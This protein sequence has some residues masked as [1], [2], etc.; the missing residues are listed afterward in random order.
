MKSASPRPRPAARPAAVLWDMDG[1]IVDTEPYWIEC[2]FELVEQFGDSWDMDKAHA[3]VGS[4]LRDTARLMQDL[5]GVRLEVDDIVNRLLDGVV[6]R[7]RRAVPWRAGAREL[8]AELNQADIPCALVTMSWTRFADAVVS[9]LPE[10]TFAAVISGDMVTNGKPH[11]EPYLAGARALR[12]PPQ[13][14]VAIEDSPTG[15]RSAVAAG[16]ITFAVPNVVD[17]APGAGY[18]VVR[19]LDDIPR[20]ILGLRSR[21][22]AAARTPEQRHRRRLVGTGLMLAAVLGLGA[23]VALLVREKGAP[24]PYPD[25]AVSTWAPYWELPAATASIAANG[26]TLHQVSPFWYTAKDAATV[27]YA[28]N[29]TLNDTAA[30]A[31]AAT[32]SGAA[33]IPTVTDGT[34]AGTMAALLANPSARST[35]VRALVALAR[36]YDG[37][38]IDYE[39][40]AFSDAYAS[41]ETTRPNWVAFIQEL[42]AA[43]HAHGKLLVVTIPPVYDTKQTPDSGR[44]VYDP[45]AIGA[46]AD[47]VR[48]MAYDYSVEL[49]GPIA[50]IA[51]VQQVVRTTKQLVGDDSKIQLG[52]P[53]YGR[54][55]VTATTGTC[56]ADAPGRVSPTQL[57]VA[58]LLQ[59]YT[60]KPTH[61]PVTDEAV[62]TYQ[63]PDGSGACTQTREVHYMDAAGVRARVDMARTERIGG[64]VFWAMG[65]ET[66]STWTAIADV[67]RPRSPLATP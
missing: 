8:L 58:D 29:I 39:N 32:A 57:E 55:W 9:V 40:F 10:G 30:F 62:F 50:P 42:A 52:I 61:S 67:S 20:S 49:P 3:L 14:C 56:P 22:H 51:W 23:G 24:P 27:A 66:T 53:L 25:M 59:R 26:G 28:A 18:T 4:D 48:I 1:T 7:V 36:D 34:G 31:A 2:E 64:V 47:F 45:K 35:H 16:C 21:G 41:W 13:H 33:V 12:V 43:L 65:F 54:N 38:D 19:S 46:V 60:V 11:P 44:W 63:R 37:L 5:G 15:V 6:Q 17:I